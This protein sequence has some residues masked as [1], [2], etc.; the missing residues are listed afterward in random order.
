M[1]KKS[2][3]SKIN[4]DKSKKESI[5]Y[6]LT[7]TDTYVKK[8]GSVHIAFPDLTDAGSKRKEIKYG[9]ENL[10]LENDYLIKFKGDWG[11]IVH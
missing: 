9:R 6:E 4:L 10:V 1:V 3:I 11:Q 5:E 8:A 2:F 7:W